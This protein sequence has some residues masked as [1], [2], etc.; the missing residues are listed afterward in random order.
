MAEGYAEELTAGRDKEFHKYLKQKADGEG[1]REGG[2]RIRLY[3]VNSPFDCSGR[4]GGG[5]F[6]LPR[7]GAQRSAIKN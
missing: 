3:D 6:R 5:I 1:G 7:S 2:R 4:G